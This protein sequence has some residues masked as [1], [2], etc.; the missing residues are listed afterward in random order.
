MKEKRPVTTPWQTAEYSDAGY[1]ILGRVLERLTGMTYEEAIHNILSAALGLNSTSTTIPTGDDVNALAITDIPITTWGFDFQGTASSGGVYANNADLRTL[2]L[3]I[4]N[5]ELLSGTVTR[6]WMKPLAHTSTLTSSVGAP[7]EISRL[8]IP[9]TAGSN[10]T[11][12]T[13]LYSKA[14][15]NPPYGAVLSLSP[16]HGIGFSVLVAGETWSIDRWTVRD[17]LAETFVPAAEL[18]AEANAVKNFVGTFVDDSIEGTNLTLTTDEGLPGLRLESMFIG[19]IDWRANLTVPG[20]GDVNGGTIRLYPSGLTAPL[21][22]SEGVV[23]MV[24]NAIPYSQPLPARTAIEGGGGL[25]DEACLAWTSVGFFPI[26]GHAIDQFM[27]HVQ[28]GRLTEVAYGAADVTMER[29][30]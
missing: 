10:R 5:H 7:W 19:G 24:F 21:P 4:L 30:D 6:Q 20:G 17:A 22:S 13:D 29:A 18:A 3:S 16:D 12:V 27:F 15:G 25:F 14:G 26:E 2:G 8:T 11:R 23:G 9:V 1:S 28:D